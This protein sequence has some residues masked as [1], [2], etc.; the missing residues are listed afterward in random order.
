MHRRKSFSANRLAVLIV[1][2]VAVAL[3]TRD[4]LAVATVTVSPSTYT[5]GDV[6]TPVVVQANTAA[7]GNELV[8]DVYIDIDG[9]KNLDPEDGRFI[10]FEIADGQ[11]P[12]LGN[13]GFWHDEDGV[14][15]SSV[16]A[17]LVANG[18]WSPSGHFIVK[19]TDKN[20]SSASASF[21]VNQNS[22]YLC[23]VRGEVQLEGAAAAGGSVV[24]IIDAVTDREVSFAV[25]GADG[26]LELRVE[27]PG[28][29]GIIAMRPDSVTKFE[30]GSAVMIEVLEGTNSLA[31]PLVLFPGSRTISGKVFCSETGEGFRGLLVFGEAESFFSLGVTDDSGNYTLNVVDGAWEWICPDQDVVSRLG[32]VPP[33]GRSVTVA[34]SDAEAMDL[35]CQRATTLIKGTVKDADTQQA[36]Q[37]YRVR[38]KLSDGGVEEVEVGVYTGV[39]GGYAIGVV[40][41]DWAVNVDRDSLIG[42]GYAR[43]RD[44]PVTAPA[45]GTVSGVDFLL[46]KAGTITGHVFKGDGETPVEGAGID[47]HVFGTWEFVAYAETLSDGSYTL[48]VPSGTYMV[49]VGEVEGWLDQYYLNALVCSESSPVVVSAPGE[50]G[51]IDFVLQRAAT[52]SGYVGQAGGTDPI[53]GAPVTASDATTGSWVANDDTDSNGDYS[54]RV[55]SGSYKVRA[56]P[57]GWVGEYYPGTYDFDLA[58][59]ITV[60]A[61]E[62]RTG[63]NFALALATGTIKGNVYR[64]DGV[65]PIPG[66]WV[67]VYD[68]SKG[69]WMGRVQSNERGFYT[70][71]VPPRTF[72]VWAEGWRCDEQFYDRK[73]SWEEA[74]P[75]AVTGSQVI[76][77]VNF[78]LRYTPFTV[79]AMRWSTAW[80]RGLEVQWERWS[81]AS[82]RVFWS[83]G[84]LSGG[85]TWREVPDIQPDLRKEGGVMI[86]TDKGTAPGMTGRPG[87]PNVPQR[88]YRVKEE[89]M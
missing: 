52:I 80:A 30:E 42:T 3:P 47:A 66:A 79:G 46:E 32:Y 10:S 57:C 73:S 59:V 70:L 75:V 35:A 63:I 88:F 84:P 39:D 69:Y 45:S 58:S 44:R 87:D 14:V 26:S 23:I 9:D 41:G 7:A 40:K 33:E 89:P 74:T 72:R 31:V 86:W 6:A 53:I 29:Y 83:P 17:T 12:H 55:P 2:V 76:E 18:A 36:L 15:N 16:K 20:L 51:G 25:A 19:V 24:Q 11:A 21:T 60:T 78:A 48:L 37:G 77:N 54:I 49:R 50:T 4:S 68:Y 82:Y 67:S 64:Q 65:T 5:L 28:E 43:P 38:G 1:A 22:S 13:P 8:F 71:L 62:E 56:D 34:G 85:M 27:S 81:Q 61:P